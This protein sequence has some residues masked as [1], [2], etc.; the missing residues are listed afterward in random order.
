ML[1]DK[2]VNILFVERDPS[3][4]RMVKDMLENAGAKLIERG[5]EAGPGDV[6]Q[7]AIALALVEVSDAA[8]AIR[9]VARVKGLSPSAPPII[10]LVSSSDHASASRAAGADEVLVEPVSM[11]SLFE[12]IGRHL[13]PG[14]DP[15]G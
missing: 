13:P 6:P 5:P 3:P 15:D 9:L 12:A 14:A 8:E 10:A 1:A 4:R 7:G 2:G 11:T